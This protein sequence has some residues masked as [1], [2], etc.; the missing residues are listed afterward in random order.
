MNELSFVM[1]R[2]YA[3]CFSWSAVLLGKQWDGCARYQES[4]RSTRAWG[5]S[6]VKAGQTRSTEGWPLSLPTRTHSR[7]TTGHAVSTTMYENH[8][9]ENVFG[10]IVSPTRLPLSSRPLA[11][12]A[13]IRLQGTVLWFV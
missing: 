6:K 11:D 4:W 1:T 8:I 7:R 12:P 2:A 10:T 13:S 3:S 9:L 5:P